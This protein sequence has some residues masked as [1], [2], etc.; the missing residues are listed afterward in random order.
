MIVGVEQQSGDM[1]HGQSD[2]GH[3]TAE[4]RGDGGEDTCH[5]QQPV[6]GAEDIDAR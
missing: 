3:R 4:G 6:A 5:D 2:E 1:G